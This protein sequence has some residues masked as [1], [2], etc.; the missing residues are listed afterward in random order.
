MKKLTILI[1]FLTILFV[2]PFFATAETWH[3]TDSVTVAWDAVTVPDGIVTYFVYVKNI[4]TGFLMGSIDTVHGKAVAETALLEQALTFT[5][6]GRYHVGIATKRIPAN[7]TEILISTINWSNIN[8]VNTPN[9]FG[10]MYF[11]VPDAP[12]NLRKE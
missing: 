5:V 4:E 6:E 1:T 10:V 9:P 3:P 7:S 12:L 8:G 2:I 11:V